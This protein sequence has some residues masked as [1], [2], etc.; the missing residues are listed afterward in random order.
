MKA[1]TYSRT[2]PPDVFGYADVP[3]PECRDSGVVIEVEAISIEGGDMLNRAGGMMAR[4][5]R[6]SS[7]TSA[8]ARSVEVG[9][10]APDRGRAEGQRV[11]ATMAN[12]SHAELV[13]GAVCSDVADPRRRRPG[14]VRVRA[15][16]LR[17][18][19]RLPVRVRPSAGG[20]DGAHP[21]GRGRRGHGR[22]PA[23]QAG[24]RHGAG[25]RVERREARR[26]SPSSGSTTASTTREHDAVDE[27]RRLTD[28]RGVDLVVDSVGGT[29]LQGSLRA[30]AYR[31]RAIT[32]GN[33]GRDR[34]PSTSRR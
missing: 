16:R 34:T 9:D 1:A 28:G 32:V 17:H 24:R 4:P 7:A 31:G 10:K 26:A 22:D 19:R 25:H 3:D 14:G 12:G 2:G 30:L 33:A 20:R 6:T 5:T 29:T 21:G 13:V 23:G 8:P 27:A 18:R 11:V 15:R